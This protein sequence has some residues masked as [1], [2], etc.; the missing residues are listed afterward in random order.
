MAT[1]TQ[2]TPFQ[3]ENGGSA[4]DL[5]PLTPSVLEKKMLG[6]L[7]RQAIYAA[8]R[9]GEIPSIKVGCRIFISPSWARENLGIR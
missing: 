2:T 9:S 3:A 5:F 8:L 1:R 7:G 4:D 6:R